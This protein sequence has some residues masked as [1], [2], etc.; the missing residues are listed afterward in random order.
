[1]SEFRKIVRNSK[2]SIEPK[3]YSVL[4]FK[5][6]CALVCVIEERQDYKKHEHTY[7]RAVNPK[8]LEK[9]KA[10]IFSKPKM[11]EEFMN[12]EETAETEIKQNKHK[13]LI[14][15]SEK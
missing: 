9:Y 7:C 11:N 6:Y 3:M 14:L 13:K 1:M 8:E 4:D 15:P 2:R 5:H 10:F 12:S